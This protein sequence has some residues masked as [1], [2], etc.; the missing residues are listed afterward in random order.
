MTVR[1]RVSYEE[2]TSKRS[3][4][5]MTAQVVLTGIAVIVADEL[6]EKYD[7]EIV[8]FM[9][10]R[11]NKSDSMWKRHFWGLLSRIHRV[12][13]LIIGGIANALKF[14]FATRVQAFFA[15]RFAI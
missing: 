4:S 3:E 12:I 7:Q 15:I 14:K 5:Q 2:K 13:R 1:T 10:D 9:K 8:A 11:S 6:L